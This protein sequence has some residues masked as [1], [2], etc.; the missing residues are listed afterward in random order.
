MTASRSAIAFAAL[1]AALPIP[2]ALSAWRS[3]DYMLHGAV[4]GDN[5]GPAL[6]AL[7]HGLVNAPGGAA[8]PEADA[9]VAAAREA[10]DTQALRH[11]VRPAAEQI[12]G[13]HKQRLAY[14]IPAVEPTSAALQA[15][16]GILVG[17]NLWLRGPQ[18]MRS[19]KPM[20]RVGRPQLARLHNQS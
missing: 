8:L 19:L 5:A 14:A 18:P 16:F 13:K 4:S 11:D 7:A 2:V 17:E 9:A 12:R 15:E 20:H 6:S 10:G 1:C 3:G